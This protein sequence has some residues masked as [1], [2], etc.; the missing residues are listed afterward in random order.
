MRR[1]LFLFWS[2]IRGSALFH[3]VRFLRDFRRFFLDWSK[4]NAENG[5]KSFHVGWRNLYPCW[6]DWNASACTLSYYFW[7][8]LWA[9]R[10]IFM[11][12]P[13]VHFDIASRVDGFI[14]HLL[15]F[16]P[17]TMLDIRPLPWQIEG[18][19]FIR[20]DATNLEQI[21]DNSIHSL[22]SLCA[23]EHFGLGRYGDPIE[24]EACFRVMNAMQRVLAPGGR[25][26]LVVPV[27]EDGVAFNAHRVFAPDTIIKSF[28][29]LQLVD[30][31]VIDARDTGHVLYREHVEIEQFKADFDFWGSVIGLFEF[32]KGTLHRGEV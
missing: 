23:V 16:M 1:T 3:P 26:Y 30:F 6:E 15:C 13:P 12:R 29:Q 8:D 24:P 4:F 5:R 14:A 10:K 9:A 21:E 25:L 11:A 28:N 32:V 17:V 2:W 19:D 31:A 27:G 18:L 7:Q 20:A 22:S